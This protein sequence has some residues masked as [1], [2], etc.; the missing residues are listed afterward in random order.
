MEFYK[1]GDY[2]I[3]R[4]LL[5]LEKLFKVIAHFDIDKAGEMIKRFGLTGLFI[6]DA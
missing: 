2:V 5:A 6:K 1:A 3:K 4:E